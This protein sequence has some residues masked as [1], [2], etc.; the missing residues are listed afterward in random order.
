MAQGSTCSGGVPIKTSRERKGSSA[1]G[2]YSFWGLIPLEN[3]VTA[4]PENLVV[5]WGPFPSS[6]SPS[7]KRGKKTSSYSND[8]LSDYGG[9]SG[10]SEDDNKILIGV[11]HLDTFLIHEMSCSDNRKEFCS[12][13]VHTIQLPSSVQKF[14]RCMILRAKWVSLKNGTAK[15]LLICTNLATYFY[16]EM[17]T[18]QLLKWSNDSSSNTDSGGGDAAAAEESCLIKC[19]RTITATNDYLILGNDKG[20]V[21][22]F[23]YDNSRGSSSKGAVIQIV[24]TLRISSEP[25]AEICAKRSG[26]LVVGTSTGNLA[27]WT[28]F[29]GAANQPV[30]STEYV[31]GKPEA[32]TGIVLW[33][34]Y[35]VVSYGSG[36]IRMYNLV[37]KVLSAQVYAHARWISS[38]DLCPGQNLLMTISEDDEARVWA[39][40]RRHKGEQR[41]PVSRKTYYDTCSMFSSLVRV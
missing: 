2:M 30:K 25:V 12:K 1:P 17:G 32:V 28:G 36:I 27:V 31:L 8:N 29:H 5:N 19:C 24:K 21:H 23:S 38:I 16:N 26:L 22:L 4:V 9:G 37:E 40:R 3:C 14:T 41:S 18:K 33:Y 13:H 6:A 20:E 10:G 34:P 7:S 39:L 11:V 35:A 15:V